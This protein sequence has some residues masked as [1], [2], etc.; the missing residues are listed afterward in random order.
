[1]IDLD[2]IEAIADMLLRHAAPLQSAVSAM[3]G[4]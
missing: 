3:R 4:A 2:D 1:V